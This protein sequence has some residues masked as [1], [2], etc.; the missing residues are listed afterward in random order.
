MVSVFLLVCIPAQPGESQ[1]LKVENVAFSEV[2]E[3][4]I[5]TYDLSAPPKKKYFIS[6]AL[7]YDFGST[8]TMTP[9][10]LEGDAGNGITAGKQKTIIW[11]YKEDYPDGLTGDG[12]VFA[13]RV[14]PYRRK[15]WVVYAL[16][17]AGIAGGLLWYY[18]NYMKKDDRRSSILTITVPADI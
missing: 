15:K 17:G 10:A 9:F 4:I 16:S 11:N 13:V 7:S 8:Y 12:F 5:L 14:E 6:V 2:N 1:E 18:D 3:K